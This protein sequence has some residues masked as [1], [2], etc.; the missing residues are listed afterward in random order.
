V[1]L[2]NLNDL[3]NLRIAVFSNNKLNVIEGLESCIRIEEL[4]LE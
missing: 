2:E 4:N 1:K 3:K